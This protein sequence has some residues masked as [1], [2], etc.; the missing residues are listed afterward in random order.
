MLFFRLNEL[1]EQQDNERAQ[2]VAHDAEK[3]SVNKRR[4][5]FRLTDIVTAVLH[6]KQRH[7]CNDYQHYPLLRFA[8]VFVKYHDR[9]KTRQHHYKRDKNY[10]FLH[11]LHFQ[12]SSVPCIIS[13]QHYTAIPT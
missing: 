12:Q 4:N 8:Y 10:I 13:K 6:Q 2:A 1:A 9:R 5:I 7:R 3:R 11:K